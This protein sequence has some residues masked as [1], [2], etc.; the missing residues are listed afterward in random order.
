[1]K[2]DTLKAK[3]LTEDAGYTCVLCKNEKIYKSRESGIKPLL[4][5]YENKEDLHSFCAA[6]KTVGRAAA[7]IYIAFGIDEIYADVMSEG[8]YE[9][10]LKNGIGAFY[11]TLTKQII[12]QAGTGICHMEKACLNAKNSAQAILAIKEKMRLLNLTQPH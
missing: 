12:N 4:M 11:G 5:F 8:A 3:K 10:L 9:L 2:T 6:D 7:F 1:M